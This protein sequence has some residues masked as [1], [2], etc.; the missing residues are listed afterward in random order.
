M[1]SLSLCKWDKCVQKNICV[2][3][4]AKQENNNQIMHFENLCDQNN[5]WKWFYGDR[6]KI[7]KVEL[8]EEKTEDIKESEIHN[9]EEKTND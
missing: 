4:N 8:I 2:R 5:D 9:E 7:I 6:S 3:Y 1:V